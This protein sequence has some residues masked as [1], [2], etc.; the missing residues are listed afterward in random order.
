MT[1][2]MTNERFL[3]RW[4]AF[5]GEPQQVSGAWLLCDA[6]RALDGGTVLLDEQAPWALR[7]SEKPPSPSTT[8]PLNVPFQSQNDN[9]SGQ[10]SRECFSSSCAML[11]MYW[12]KVKNDDEY[13]K[14]RARYGDTT[15]AEAQLSALRSLGLVANFYTNWG[16][17]NLV[18]QI[19]RG[20][21]VATG[22]LHHSHFTSPS[23]GGHWTVCI[24]H[25]SN[26]TIHND[27]NGKPD[28]VNGNYTPD[29]NGKALSFA[30]QHWLPR[31]MPDGPNTGWTLLAYP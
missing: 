16:K 29:L 25:S 14:V 27:P 17:A 18:E 21:P 12:G 22:W 26:A 20:R 13:N 24:G 8:N 10:G 4:E 31:F 19:N 5:K 28:L 23:G 30:D 9:A 15:S 11:A 2:P 6:I 7:F 3:D 1:T